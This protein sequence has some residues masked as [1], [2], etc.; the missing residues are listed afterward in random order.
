MDVTKIIN[1]GDKILVAQNDFK[2]IESLESKMD[3][4]INNNAQVWE[5]V[6]KRRNRKIIGT[7]IHISLMASSESRNLLVSASEWGL[8][9]RAGISAADNELQKKLV[10]FL[11]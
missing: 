6:Y 3:A 5:K 9:P 1:K 4:F 7:I 10:T 2:L 11:N 8:N